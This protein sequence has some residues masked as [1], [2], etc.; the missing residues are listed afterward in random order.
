[1]ARSVEASDCRGGSV[2]WGREKLSSLLPSMGASAERPS[3][4]RLP[5]SAEG[6][7]VVRQALVP[8]SLFPSMLGERELIAVDARPLVLHV[9]R[10]LEWAGVSRAVVV[11]GK[12]A[13]QM[14]SAVRRERF[15]TLRVELLW[16][17]EFNWGS[18]L[19]NSIMAARGAFATEGEPLL[20]VRSDYLYDWRLLHKMARARF[21][22]G[23]DAFALVDKAQETLEWISGAHCTAH[24]KNGHC[25]ALVKVLLANDGRISRIGHRLGAY[26]ALQAGVYAARPIIFGELAQL[27]RSEKFCTVA[28]SMQA[29]A[30][31]GRLQY[32]E[33]ADLPWFGHET[34]ESALKEHALK[35]VA[36]GSPSLSSWKEQALQL[37]FHSSA[38]ACS[39]P[40]PR[41]G[42]GVP[43]YELGAAI[44]EGSNGTVHLGQAGP[45]QR[46][47]P[48]KQLPAPPRHPP[49]P[50]KPTV[51]RD[52]AGPSEKRKHN[53]AV[54][55]VRKG[56]AKMERVMWEVHVLQLLK[57]CSHIVKLLDVVNLVDACYMIMERVDGPDLLGHIR[58]QPDGHLSLSDSCRLFSQLLA[59]LRHAHKVGFVHCDIKPENVRL[60][61]DC[62]NAILVDWGYARRIGKQTDPITQGTPA[63]AAPE[64]LTG[65][66]ADG[67]SARRT[68]SPSVDVWGLGATLCEMV[69]GFPPF[70]G[71]SF[72]ELVQHVLALRFKPHLFEHMADEP[73]AI[74]ESM[75]QIHPSDRASIDELCRTPWVVRGGHLPSLE[76]EAGELHL[77]MCGE[78]ED[79]SE[80]KRW[81]SRAGL[82]LSG[83]FADR[84]VLGLL[85]FLI[86]A[87]ALIISQ[88]LGFTYD[89]SAFEIA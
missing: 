16:G 29:L 69:S 84:R 46:V 40:A 14:A 39:P 32:I 17:D 30:S 13:E 3:S 12:G 20:I 51:S 70:T 34:V 54:K 35:S 8:A 60:T 6:E 66:T 25:H 15:A 80:A 43:L 58:A 88:H 31:H 76:E 53:L 47:A 73:R 48:S 24:C 45:R 86:C 83:A 61:A 21:A 59:A 74:I 67:F 62:A 2:S 71:A 68:L 78:C 10:G 57:N 55:V 72:E 64:Q 11:L 4:A 44:G 19:A 63:Y 75:L 37:L 82:A 18:S 33:V 9:L 27:L 1:M 26:D 5:E 77:G 56:Q 22:A 81:R 85:Y 87:A 52:D 50:E 89:A 42:A 7:A 65:V 28:D 79:P 23:V 49:K 41:A 38:H 36:V